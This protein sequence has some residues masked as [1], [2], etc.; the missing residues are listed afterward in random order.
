MDIQ[1]RL[2]IYRLDKNFAF[3][4]IDHTIQRITKR[5]TQPLPG[6]L[7]RDKLR[8]AFR[9]IPVRFKNFDKSKARL[10]GV[11]IMLYPYKGSLYTAFMQRGL[12]A[13]AHSGQISFPGGGREEG[14]TDL[15]FTALR[16]TEEEFG[17]SRKLIKVLGSLTEFYIPVSNSLV[18]PT[19]GFLA[20][21]PVF[22]PDPRE[23][24]NIIEVD[25]MDLLK[26]NVVKRTIIKASSGYEVE[27]GYYDVDNHVIWGATAMMLTELL[28]IFP[29]K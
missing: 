26:E 18:L 25:I 27:A 23:V 12:D 5:L 15:Q 22:T 28:A 11:L 3:M 4:N 29:R 2:L 14:D 8:P 20:K 21:R 9:S 24:A 7:V 19:I 1:K 13:Y 17:V 16:E 10:C 6:D